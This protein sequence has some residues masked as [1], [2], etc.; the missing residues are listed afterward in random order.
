MIELLKK[1]SKLSNSK[2]SQSLYTGK[3]VMR[4][5]N[6]TADDNPTEHISIP[7]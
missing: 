1:F 5:L 3:E 2:S 7:N 6:Y 4:N